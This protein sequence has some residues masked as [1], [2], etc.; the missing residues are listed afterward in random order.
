LVCP[1]RLSPPL[2]G[3]FPQDSESSALGVDHAGPVDGENE[4]P[5]AAVRGTHGRRWKSEPVR[6]EPEAGKTGEDNVET[7]PSEGPNV[8]DEDVFWFELLGDSLVLKPEGRALALADSLPSPG[9]ADVLAREAASDE[10]HKATPRATVEGGDV[11]PDRSR[12][13]DRIFHPC[14]E[15]GCGVSVPLN[16]THGSIAGSEDKL[17]ASFQ[18]CNP[19]E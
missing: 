15:S 4:E 17:K 3:W 9:V 7:S 18:A 10:I 8:F 14:H 6:I 11:V 13:Q 19:G 16:E 5:L 1:V 12:I 2:P